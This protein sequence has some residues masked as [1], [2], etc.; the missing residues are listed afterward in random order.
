M[1]VIKYD[2]CCQYLTRICVGAHPFTSPLGWSD[3]GRHA[4]HFSSLEEA[5]EA[6]AFIVNV[7]DAE[8]EGELFV[9]RVPS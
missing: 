3:A 1:Y 4:I 6:V 5:N 7:I 2:Y 8:L 9:L